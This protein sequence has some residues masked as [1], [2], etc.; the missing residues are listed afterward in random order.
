MK[1]AVVG[2]R[3][4]NDW[5]LFKS[6]MDKLTIDEM[7]SGGAP[8]ADAFAERYA[9]EN[10]IPMTVLPADWNKHGRAAG[11][12]RN[13]DIWDASTSGIAFWDG[14]SKG[15]KHSFDIAKKQNKKLIIVDY[16]NNKQYLANE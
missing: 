10:N 3:G 11:F 7:V 1:L 8:G 12:I 4:F 9:K 16:V 15:T 2:S 13:V 14:E 6:I 5:N